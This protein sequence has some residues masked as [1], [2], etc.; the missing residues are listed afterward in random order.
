MALM[1]SECQEACPKVMDMV[2]AMS[3]AEE[4]ADMVATYC[5]H[6]DT[7]TCIAETKGC[8]DEGL[9][10]M[11]EAMATIPCFCSCPDLAK[12]EEMDEKD[13]ATPEVCEIIGCLKSADAC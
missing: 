7:L 10:S 3:G 13:G 8:L 11:M 2:T 5:P 12:M 6:I 9:E 4:G 1:S